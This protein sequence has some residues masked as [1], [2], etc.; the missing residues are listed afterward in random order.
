[1]PTTSKMGIVYPSSSDLVKDGATAMGTI[2]TTVD[3]K[4]G[5]ILLN[6]TS[7]SAVSSQIFAAATFSSTYDYYRIILLLKSSVA[8]EAAT[9]QFRSGTTN[10]TTAYYGSGLQVTTGG[11]VGANGST[12]NGSSAR[13]ANDLD[14]NNQQ[15]ITMDISGVNNEKSMV[16]GLAI[17]QFNGTFRSFGYQRN[18]TETNDAIVITPGSGTITGSYSVYGYNK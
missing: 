10:R 9:L 17:S 8:G 15:L 11:T 6:T 3:N 1:M 12:S 14:T 5:F 18:V 16:I 4:T 2:A 7:F 13:I